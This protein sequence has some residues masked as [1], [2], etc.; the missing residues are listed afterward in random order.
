M[1]RTTDTKPRDYAVFGLRIRSDLELPDL[2]ECSG[3]RRPD[4]RI[5]LAGRLSRDLKAQARPPNAGT[6]LMIDGV[7]R[8]TVRNG[9]EIIVEPVRGVPEVN[10]RLYLL[11]SAMGLLLH[12]R[13]LLPLHANAIEIGGSAVLFMGPSGEGKSTLAAL[14]HDWGHR[15]IADDVC[16][17]RF[18]S[19]HPLASPGIPRLRLWK[20]VIDATG[21]QPSDYARS[22]A[23][24][25]TWEK[26]DVPIRSDRRTA[27]NLRIA[28]I[29]LL[30]RGEGLEISALEGVAAADALFANT[31]RGGYVDSA[32]DPQ[33]HYGAC[34][35]LVR[36]TPIFS[37]S[38][39]WNLASMDEEVGQLVAHAEA[40]AK[41]AFP[42]GVTS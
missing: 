2:V 17:V 22:Y 36:Q 35:N 31:Y 6:E 23:G 18:E 9:S 25:E 11:G 29:Y 10:V 26:Y 27:E 19:G 13:G 40:L 15:I 5:R 1:N 7:A 20:D 4:V 38:R 42:A 16:V 39:S 3:G 28:A 41:K 30:S 33:S 14:L 21:R 8:Y 24:D 37:V 12:Q 32:G 34:L